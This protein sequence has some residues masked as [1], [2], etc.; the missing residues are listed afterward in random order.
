MPQ[1]V[2]ADAVVQLHPGPGVGAAVV[3][4]GAGVGALVVAMQIGAAP[5]LPQRDC[6]LKQR[7]SL[8]GHCPQSYDKIFSPETRYTR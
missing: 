1:P 7:Q 5:L 2:V 6:P 4:V 8:F 3:G